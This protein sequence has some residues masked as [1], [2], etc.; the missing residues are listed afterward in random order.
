MA[1]VLAKYTELALSRL[2]KGELA[3]V[4]WLPP[5]VRGRQRIGVDGVPTT[6]LPSTDEQLA[7]ITA[8]DPI[9]FLLAVMNGQ[10]LLTF[11]VVKSEDEIGKTRKAGPRMRGATKLGLQVTSDFTVVA[12][13]HTPS[14][15]DRKQVAL[16]LAGIITAVKGRPGPRP[17]DAPADAVDELD[18]MIEMAAQRQEE[19]A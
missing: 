15:A 13:Y 14:V 4:V 2:K 10:P 18:A 19:Q 9:G 5:E 3:E 1:S 17:K 12:E 16:E 11:K 6:A 7:R 8:A